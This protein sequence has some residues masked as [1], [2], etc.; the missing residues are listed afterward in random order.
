MAST[1]LIKNLLGKITLN[2]TN[3]SDKDAYVLLL[4]Q[5][6]QQYTKSCLG[7]P[8]G[9]VFKAL[10]DGLTYKDAWKSISN[11]VYFHLLVKVTSIVNYEDMTYD[12]AD[13]II[14]GFDKIGIDTTP[15]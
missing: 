1:Y 3:D 8:I 13:C 7:T 15:F 6:L 14:A 10:L 5:A 11:P 2:I 12:Q 4:I 9:S